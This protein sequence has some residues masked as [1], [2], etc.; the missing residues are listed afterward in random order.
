MPS[1]PSL[2]G[3]P[4]PPL[5][6]HPFDFLTKDSPEKFRDTSIVVR[7]APWGDTSKVDREEETAMGRDTKGGG[8]RR[9]GGREERRRSTKLVGKWFGGVI[10]FSVSLQFVRKDGW[11]M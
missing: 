3:G 5:C 9:R 8:G 6:F 1:A 4:K 11:I 2:P 10:S 7:M